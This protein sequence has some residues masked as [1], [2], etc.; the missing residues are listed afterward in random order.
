MYQ[1]KAVFDVHGHVSVPPAANTY[2]LSL[3]ATNSPLKSPLVAPG[4]HAYGARPSTEEY[5]KAAA[6]HVAYMDERNIDVQVIG[7]RPF[8]VLGHVLEPYSFRLWT[9]HVNTTIAQQVSFHPD[10]FL[11]AALLPQD[12][13]AA[14]STHMVGT[15]RDCVAEGFVAA[16]VSP[17]PKGRR[18]TP[19]LHEP[20]WYPLY[21][22][23]VELSVPVIVHG[24]NTVDPRLHVVPQNYQIGFLVEQFIA[25]EIL[26]HSDVF[27][28]FPALR[29]IVCHCGGALSRFLASSR[30]RSQKDLSDNLFF[31]TCAHDID[32]LTAAIRQR[33]V[34]QSVFG[35][36]AP[37]AGAAK[38]QAGEGPGI[39]ADDLVPVLD[40]FE[41]LSLADRHRILH[42]TPLRLVP[43]FAK[44][45]AGADR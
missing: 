10:R 30:H 18:T 44:S 28:R 20:Y 9:E 34:A 38:R 3:L 35:T 43:A 42:D 33:G 29:V 14:D 6:R 8:M 16:Y 40:S 2:A 32:F 27:E 21:E 25:A 7:P 23:C 41:W 22:A 39:S 13:D 5:Q 37:G 36:E 17:D 31:D 1:D 12:S 15:L 26:S 45:G 24:T 19:G 11:G 4:Q